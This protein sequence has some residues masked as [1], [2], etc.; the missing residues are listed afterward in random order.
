MADVHDSYDVVLADGQDQNT[1]V[2]I[3]DLEVT[4]PTAKNISPTK[5][6]KLVSRYFLVAFAAYVQC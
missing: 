5:T 3:P 6:G 1:Q 4:S 2:E